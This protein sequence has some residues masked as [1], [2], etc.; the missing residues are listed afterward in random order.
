MATKK[1]IPYIPAS[2]IERV[3]SGIPGLDG[4]ICG[5]FVENSRLPFASFNKSLVHMLRFLLDN[6]FGGA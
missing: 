6:P 5:G 1:K 4:M 2:K 3:P